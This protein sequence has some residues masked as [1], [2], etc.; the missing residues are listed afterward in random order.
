M[1]VSIRYSG[2]IDDLDQVEEFEDRI[3][4][5]VYSLGGQVNVWRSYSQEFPG[6][7]MRGLV[8]E[9]APGQESL[10][11][12][13]SPEGYFTPLH[14]LN[15]AEE[16]PYDQAPECSV[17]TQ[18]GGLV[19]HLTVCHLL[20][21]IKKHFASDLQITDESGF[22]EKRDVCLLQDEFGF[23]DE[24]QGPPSQQVSW[25][26]LSR[27]AAEDPFILEQRSR[28]I[29]MLLDARLGDHFEP[30]LK[31]SESAT[32]LDPWMEIPL[33]EEVQ[34]MDSIRRDNE[35]RNERI[36]RVVRDAVANGGDV[37]EAIK[38][39]LE[40]D[41]PDHGSEV[42][43]EIWS[44]DGF[45][46]EEFADPSEFQVEDEIDPH[47]EEQLRHPVLDIA[48]TFYLDVISMFQNDD[49]EPSAWIA[50][51]NGLV[52][53]AGDIVGGLVQATVGHLTE[54]ETGTVS[55]EFETRSDRALAI[56][57]LK[58]AQRG[59][60]FARGSIL[61]LISLKFFDER[62]SKELLDDLDEILFYIRELASLAWDES[63]Y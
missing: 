24:A 12:I 20:G 13:L 54:N 11:L 63:V 30:L 34:K 46:P 26:G 47:E 28:R 45:D 59:H 4:D 44:A 51:S 38:A 18:L 14:E 25:F 31:K 15:R 23:V 5:V 22:W 35:L 62:K 32:D 8:I 16:V 29:A 43:M 53:A 17:K 7:T 49:H 37:E 33:E 39:A 52:A 36:S 2:Q 57:Q 1:G 50:H 10:S 60:G 61:S 48:E 6:R 27:E 9:V 21:A 40:H 41:I 58:R 56:S 42:S 3:M 19:G 55:L